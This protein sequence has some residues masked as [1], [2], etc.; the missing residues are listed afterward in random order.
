MEIN[1]DSTSNIETLTQKMNEMDSEQISFGSDKKTFINTI[2]ITNLIF[3]VIPMMIMAIL[4]INKP[5]IVTK[6]VEDTKDKT[7]KTKKLL[8][9]RL[10][11]LTLIISLLFPAAYYG[12]LYFYK[13]N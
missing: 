7:K 9:M 12:Y 1:G 8:Y 5:S 11:G 13:K 2:G 3:L 4:V 6:E 10:L